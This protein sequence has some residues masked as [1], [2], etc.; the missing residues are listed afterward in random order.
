MSAQKQ[1]RLSMMKTVPLN[2]IRFLLLLS[3]APCVILMRIPTTLTEKS[4]A[5]RETMEE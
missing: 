3:N 4:S 1:N 5:P 2:I